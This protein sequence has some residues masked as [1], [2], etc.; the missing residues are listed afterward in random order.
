MVAPIL[1]LCLQVRFLYTEKPCFLTP[2]QKFVIAL[3]FFFPQEFYLRFS[4][5]KGGDVIGARHRP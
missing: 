5:F 4:R 1:L 3:V 2:I